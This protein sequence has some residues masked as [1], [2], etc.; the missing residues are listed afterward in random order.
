[1][2]PSSVNFP[3]AL[4]AG[5]LKWTFLKNG[6]SGR[7]VSWWT[8][9]VG[10]LTSIGVCGSVINVAL[11]FTIDCTGVLGTCTRDGN[12]AEKQFYTKLKYLSE[13]ILKVVFKKKSKWFLEKVKA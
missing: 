10:L 8:L 7:G 3:C 5:S 2:T 13:I 12:G 11:F 9:L 4:C 1:M 6:C